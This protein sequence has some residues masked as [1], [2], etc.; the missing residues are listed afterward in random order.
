[1]EQI[2]VDINEKISVALKKYSD[3]VRRICF[4]YLHSSADV[5]DI[6]QEVF[7]KLLQNETKFE[8]DEHEKAWLIRVTINKCKDML[9][10]FWRKKVDATE[11]I[12][13]I[14]KAGFEDKAESE[15]MEIV[16]S[17]PDKYKDVI[18]LFYY[19]EYTV[20][21]IAK[22]LKKNENTIYSHLHRARALIKQK[23]GGECNDY[24]F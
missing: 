16:L 20:P 7:L 19:E 21:E 22:L 1:M 3:M 11:S 15:L 24:S 8:S 10:S 23:L 12:E 2:Q 13:M 4:I 5:D 6:F 9:K 17:L 14:N 18:Y